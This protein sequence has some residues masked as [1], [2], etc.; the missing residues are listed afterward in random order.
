VKVVL[1]RR[2]FADLD[3]IADYI[4][5]NSPERALDFA[6][7]LREKCKELGDMP[8]AWPVKQG[9][10]PMNA[11]IRHWRGYLIVYVVLAQR[12]DVLH[13]VNGA[14]DLDALLSGGGA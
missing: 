5:Q 13:V 1:T 3:A 10:N 6:I 12:I 14:R 11:R 2:A 8:E 9:Y 7:A 4:G